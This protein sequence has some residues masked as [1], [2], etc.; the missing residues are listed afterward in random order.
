MTRETLG[1]LFRSRIRLQPQAEDS[2]EDRRFQGHAVKQRG[3]DAPERLQVGRL[4][5]HAL[6]FLVV[7]VMTLLAV[8]RTDKDLLDLGNPFVGALSIGFLGNRPAMKK[9][10]EP[11][12][13]RNENKTN[14]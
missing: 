8:L 6:P 9:R 10:A 14:E 12:K 11:G 7:P 4:L 1:P 5:T 3:I 2:L 13:K